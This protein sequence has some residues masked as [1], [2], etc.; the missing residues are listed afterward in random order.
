MDDA[1]KR[2]IAYQTDR[3]HREWL[4]RRMDKQVNVG[5]ALVTALVLLTTLARLLGPNTQ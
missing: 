1:T 4:R 3:Q 5:I 2:M